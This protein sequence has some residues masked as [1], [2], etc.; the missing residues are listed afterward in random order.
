MKSVP[1]LTITKTAKGRLPRLPFAKMKDSVLGKDYRL[2]LVFSSVSLM[3]KLNRQFRNKDKA[4]DI[5][6]FPLDEKNG[7]IFISLEES[8]KE[9]EIFK[10]GFENFLSFLFIHGLLHLKGMRHGS[11]MESE[12]RKY[13]KK[14]GV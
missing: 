13:R 10:R 5:L 14:F 3:R 2:S 1:T 11:T 8:R 4:T 7:E 12:E 9:A 6:S